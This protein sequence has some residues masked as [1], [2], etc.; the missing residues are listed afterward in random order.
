MSH[1]PP[2]QVGEP[3]AAPGQ[4]WPHLPQFDVSEAVE[5]QPPSHA[6]VPLGQSMPHSPPAHTSPASHCTAQSPQCSASELVSTHAPLQSVR[7]L[8]HAMSQPSTVHT[9]APFGGASQ[10]S[11]QAPQ[12][13]MSSSK[14][15]QTPWHGE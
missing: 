11:S 6:S 4:T 5:T 3:P 8:L 7:P 10:I 13:S 14:R 15:T 2:L 1:V 12:L 9:A